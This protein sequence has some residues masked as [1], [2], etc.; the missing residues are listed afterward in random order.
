MSKLVY[1]L[2]AALILCVLVSFYFYNTST[3]VNKSFSDIQNIENIPKSSWS[4]LV[5][6]PGHGIA[7]RWPILSTSLASLKHSVGNTGVKFSCIIYSYSDNLHLQQQN[8]CEIVDSQGL[9]THHMMKVN[10]SSFTHVAVL[11]D[12]VDV[13]GVRLPSAIATMDYFKLDVASAAM[14]GWHYAHMHPRSDCIAHAANFVDVL[15]TL[16]T[17][18]A[19]RCWQAQLDTSLN[20]TG[21]GYDLTL[22]HLCHVHIGVLDRHK[23]R[24]GHIASGEAAASG[25]STRSYNTTDANAQLLAWIGKVYNITNMRRRQRAITTQLQQAPVPAGSGSDD[26]GVKAP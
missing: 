16:F 25:M 5:V 26:C 20:P 2:V 24:H 3:D 1:K 13:T 21:W 4:I 19:W 17:A 8:M 22:K 11:M 10:S 14:K 12:D 7:D 23:G 9:W 15:F 18:D 6:I